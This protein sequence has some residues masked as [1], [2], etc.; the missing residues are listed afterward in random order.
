MLVV[1]VEILISTSDSEK[2][3]GGRRQI[4][5]VNNS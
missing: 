4:K 2:K 1:V 3:M 5:I